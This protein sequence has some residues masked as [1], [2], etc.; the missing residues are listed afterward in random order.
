MGFPSLEI[1]HVAASACPITIELGVDALTGGGGPAEF[2]QNQLGGPGDTGPTGG[3][4]VDLDSHKVWCNYGTEENPDWRRVDG[5]PIALAD[6]ADLQGSL[7]NIDQAIGNVVDGLG[8]VVDGLANETSD[9]QTGDA[10]NPIA[11]EQFG[12]ISNAGTGSPE[13]LGTF[14]AGLPDGGCL[15]AEWAGTWDGHATATFRL[16]V[17]KSVDDFTFIDSG[18]LTINEA[19]SWRIRT[20]AIRI[21][22]NSF[23]CATEILIGGTVAMTFVSTMHS[24]QG[25][26]GPRLLAT[27]DGVGAAAD[28]L[29]CLLSRGVYYQAP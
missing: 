8:N 7:G 2:E 20:T 3:F 21:D 29:H 27:V 16:H 24:P 4:W 23:D 12:P 5:V 14:D 15:L 13:D 9:R 10:K 1:I 11:I 26:S 6:V 17:K 19:V 22:A 28:M 18:D 25:L